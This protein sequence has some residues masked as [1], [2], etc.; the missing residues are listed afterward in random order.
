MKSSFSKCVIFLKVCWNLAPKS[1][2]VI[3]TRKLTSLSVTVK[4]IIVRARNVEKESMAAEQNVRFSCFIQT[5]ARLIQFWSWSFLL[6]FL[7]IR[8]V[9]K[10][11][12]TSSNSFSRSLLKK[13]QWL[14]KMSTFHFQFPLLGFYW[15]RINGC[16]ERCHLF[17][18]YSNCRPPKTILAMK[19]SATFFLYDMKLFLRFF[20]HSEDFKVLVHIFELLF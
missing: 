5:A 15:K 11:L 19:F 1:W 6:F 16:W 8:K 20:S 14:S 3:V 18:F 12:S 2:T 13:N 17:I 10:F 7:C 9:S 4:P